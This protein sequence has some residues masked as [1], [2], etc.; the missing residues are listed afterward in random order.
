[1]Y[2]E[3]EAEARRMLEE[4]ERAAPHEQGGVVTGAV[5]AGTRQRQSRMPQASLFGAVGASN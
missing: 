2:T 1:M 3:Q 5:P 4:A